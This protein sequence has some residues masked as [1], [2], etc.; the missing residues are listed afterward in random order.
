MFKF[1]AKQ[2]PRGPCW[3]WL[4]LKRKDGTVLGLAFVFYFIFVRIVLLSVS[5]GLALGI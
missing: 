3:S 5:V 4:G 1:S 2:D